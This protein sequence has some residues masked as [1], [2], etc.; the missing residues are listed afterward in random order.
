MRSKEGRVMSLEEERAA[1]IEPE[2]TEEEL[3]TPH[4]RIRVVRQIPESDEGEYDPETK[5]FIPFH[6]GE[7]ER[8]AA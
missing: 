8:K 2:Y 6:R 7:E 3:E 5:K 4:G 1:G